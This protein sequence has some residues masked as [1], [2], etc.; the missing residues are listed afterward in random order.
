MAQINS[1]TSSAISVGAFLL[2]VAF[3]LLIGFTTGDYLS[4][5]WVVL[6]VFGLYVMVASRLKSDSNDSFGP[7][8][9]DVMV[10]GG[11]VMAGLGAA[12]LVYTYTGEVVYTAVVILVVVAV[13]GIVMAVKNR[14]V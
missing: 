5:V 12:G 1:R 9:A 11:V 13:T 3:G 8:E 7:S 2:A 6:I 4:A 14:S 10:A